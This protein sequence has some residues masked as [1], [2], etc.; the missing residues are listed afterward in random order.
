MSERALR[1]HFIIRESTHI[2]G[3]TTDV[4]ADRVQTNRFIYQRQLFAW[5]PSY[6]IGLLSGD[7]GELSVSW[8]N[9]IASIDVA[10]VL[11]FEPH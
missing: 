5:D 2:Y 9:P 8:Q 4:V 7:S 10:E 11:L 3:G 1:A 6:G